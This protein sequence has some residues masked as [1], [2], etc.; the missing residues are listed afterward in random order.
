M[1]Y[2]RYEGENELAL[3][4]RICKEKDAIGTW[5]DVADILNNLLNYEYTSSKYRKDF[6][7]FEKVLEANQFRFIDF[8]EQLATLKLEKRELEK[9]KKQIQ[10]EKLEY[11]KYLREE[12]RDDLICEKI[13]NAI[14]ELEPLS[15]PKYLEKQYIP[16]KEGILMFGDCH[17]GVEFQILGLMGEILNE[18]NENIFEERMFE[19]QRQTIEIIKKENLTTINVYDLGD[20]IDGI[21]R[22]GQLSKLKYGVVEQTTKYS[23]FI[24]KWLNELTRYVNVRYQST[25]GNH[26]ELRMLGQPKNTFHEDNMQKITD[27]FIVEMLKD[28]PNFEFIKNPTGMIY[29]NVCGFNIVGIHGEVK[30]M[31]N[32]LKNFANIYD[33]K[34]DYLVGGH[35]HHKITEEVGINKEVINVPSIIGIDPYSMSIQK[36]SNAGAKVLIFENEKGKTIEYSIKLN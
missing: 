11:N 27:V 32:T 7:S 24:C 30:N 36:Y 4:Y 23:A 1:N 13:I 25:Y 16:N 20:T 6:Q 21:L 3:I 31:E 17:L 19:L 26:S 9:L 22:V 10:T 34:I 15:V 2:Q 29:D 28:N 18:Y 5:E 14:Q 33:V 12:A 8:D 35:K